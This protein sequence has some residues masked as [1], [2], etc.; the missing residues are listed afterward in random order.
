MPVALFCSKNA[1]CFWWNAILGPE[2]TFG[3]AEWKTLFH[4]VLRQS[5][6]TMNIWWC[7]AKHLGSA[8]KKAW[9]LPSQFLIATV[10]S[11]LSKQTAVPASSQSSD[12]DIYS[13]SVTERL[14]IL[15]WAAVVLRG[16]LSVCV[17]LTEARRDR[18]SQHAALR[19]RGLGDSSASGAWRDPENSSW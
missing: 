19:G 18:I 17:S 6:G 5:G 1:F 8:Y 7:K 14:F 15:Q 12:R 2:I 10:K 3:F 16:R 13:C 9:H 4:Q 11:S